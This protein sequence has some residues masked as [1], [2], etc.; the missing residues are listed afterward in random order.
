MHVVLTV[1]TADGTVTATTDKE[2]GTNYSALV[3]SE[4]VIRGVAAPLVNS[5]RQLTGIRLLFPG[6]KTVTITEPAPSDPFLLPVRS[7]SSLLQYSPHAAS[8]HRI[9]LRGRVTL[10]WPG[11]TVCVVDQTAG[12]C[13]QTA[14]RTVLFEG[15]LIDVAGFLGREDYLPSI[16]AATPKLVK[17]G[18]PLT[19]VTISAEA[20]ETDHEDGGTALKAAHTEIPMANAFE[21][22]RNGELVRVE[23]TLVGRNQGL[24][25]STLLLSSRGVLFS[26]APPTEAKENEKQIESSWA[27][28]STITV[29]GVFV[30]KVDEQQTTRQE[31]IARLASFQIL[32]RSPKDVVVIRKPSP[33][34]PR[35][36]LILLGLLLT[37]TLAALAWVVAL[38]KR[39]WRQ[40]ILLRESEERFRHMALHDALTGLA[41]RLLLRDRLDTAVDAA[42]RRQTGLALL[43]VDLDK[44]KDINDTFGHHAGDEVLRVTADRLLAAVRKADTVARFGGDEFVILLADLRDP[45]IAEII[46]SKIVKNLAAPIAFDELTLPVSV[47]VGICWASAKE[48]D[49][50]ELLKRADEA[51][52][53]AKESGRN[54]YRV[55]A[56]GT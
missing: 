13:I 43:M 40:T 34:T 12:L 21:T 37:G 17:S 46:A 48:L 3:D 25:G 11:H 36:V 49:A 18:G 53:Q 55:F 23:G 10:S 6:M 2:D 51:L 41:T 42:R 38:R 19:P 56:P 32:L 45:R 22:D 8:L 29:T 39:V 27:D 54:R 30:G 16:T 47:S 35:R 26:V 14:D 50:D 44:F 24:N 4:I 9:H 52:Y 7:L 20:F 31:G 5:R 15:D 1:A 28:G 33:W